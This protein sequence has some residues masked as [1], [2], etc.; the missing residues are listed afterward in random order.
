[1]ISITKFLKKKGITPWYGKIHHG[2]SSAA[3]GR[4]VHNSCMQIDTGKQYKT[5]HKE[6]YQYKVFKKKYHPRWSKIEFPAKRR[7]FS[8][9]IDRYGVLPGKGHVLFEIKTGADRWQDK[10]YAFYQLGGYKYLTQCNAKIIMAVFLKPDS[11]TVISADAKKW[12]KKF[13]SLVTL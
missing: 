2:K 1:M 5:R 13:L 3:I 12:E 11:F 6:V 4:S 9:R 8:G 10:R 7:G